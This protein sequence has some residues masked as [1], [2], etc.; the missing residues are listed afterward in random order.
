MTETVSKNFQQWT[1]DAVTT[2]FSMSSVNVQDESHLAVYLD[3]T[4]KTITT[5]YTVAIV[6]EIATVTFLSA[7]DADV[8]V[9]V[10]RQEPLEQNTDLTTI[11]TFRAEGFEGALDSI[12]RQI[13]RLWHKLSRSLTLPDSNVDGSGQFDARSNRIGSVGDP[14]D[15]QDVVTKSFAE[16][17]YALQSAGG[18]DMF[19][20]SYDSNADG[21]VDSADTAAAAPWSGITGKPSV[22][23][24]DT[25]SHAASDITDFTTAADARLAASAQSQAIWEAGTG[26]TESVVS[27]EK[28][29]AAIAALAA[30]GGDML[31]A[32][33]LSD[34]DNAAT[35]R[36]NLGVDAAGT[37]NSTNVTIAAGRDYISISSQELTLGAV[38]LAADV[39]GDLPVS[40]LNGGTSASSSTFWRGDGT[41][42]TPAGG[43]GGID[44]SGTPVA[45]DFARFTDADTIEGRSYAEVR[46][47]LGLE[48]GTDVQA[49]DADTA[50]TDVAQ[51][52][53]ALQTC[54][55]EV[56]SDGATVTPTGA[57]SLHTLTLGGNRT[58]ANPTTITAGATYVFKITQDGTGSRTLS[59]GAA[60]DWAGGTAPTL[61]TGAGDVDVF[62]GISLD[63]TSIQMV[64]AG[65][66]YS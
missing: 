16:N 47:D 50:K 42:A 27:P 3:D 5:D 20:A 8:R 43:G 44:T 36:T 30:G 62:S 17:R 56:L 65:Q 33:N 37:D 63:G 32:N 24:P 38:D 7:P 51:E 13:Y 9:T 40:N 25:H 60:Y 10:V 1:G 23:T 49:Y 28:V 4:L 21:T 26:T 12:V 22:F 58:L 19:K 2:A 54:D 14:E 61:S 41:W 31:A 57:L 34:L 39:T 46:A 64:T 11:N 48:I 59:W 6:S 45:N 55:V 53:T 18:G 66:D 35:A 15:D 52:F 29:A